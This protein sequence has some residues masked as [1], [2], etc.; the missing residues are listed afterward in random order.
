MLAA[1]AKR[2]GGFAQPEVVAERGKAYT[3]QL[4]FDASGNG[5]LAWVEPVD[6]RVT[7]LR[8]ARYDGDAADTPAPAAK[9]LGARVDGDRVRVRLR[10][11]SAVRMA[12]TLRRRGVRVAGTGWRRVR[13]GRRSF[14]FAA[15]RRVSG[16]RAVVEMRDRLGRRARASVSVRQVPHP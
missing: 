3:S 9:A 10:V 13:P 15:P 4:L 8:V 11:A 16:L 14:A 5:L 2:G 1:R 12:V 7:R 6:G